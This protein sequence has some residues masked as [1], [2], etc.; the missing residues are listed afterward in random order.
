METPS[1]MKVSYSFSDGEVLQNSLWGSRGRLA[2]MWK[3]LDG[4]MNRAVPVARL[5]EVRRSWRF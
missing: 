2:Q 1:G 3:P 4:A 5:R